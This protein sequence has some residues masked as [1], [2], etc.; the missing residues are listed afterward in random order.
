MKRYWNQ[1]DEDLFPDEEELAE[2]A[3]LDELDVYLEELS[4]AAQARV[5]AFYGDSGNLGVFPLF[6]LYKGDAP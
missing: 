5:L 6:T 4:P 2:I 3:G 1:Q